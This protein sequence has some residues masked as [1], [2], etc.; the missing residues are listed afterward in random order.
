MIKEQREDLNHRAYMDVFEQKSP[1]LIDNEFY[2]QSYRFWR[3]VAGESH[4][5]SYYMYANY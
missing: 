5:D 1:Q 2:M 3:S 4:F